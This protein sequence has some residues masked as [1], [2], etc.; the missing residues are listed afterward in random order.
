MPAR[1]LA[2]ALLLALC[3]GCATFSTST[4]PEW[5]R[6]FG[7]RVRATL[8]LQLADPCAPASDT[9]AGMDGRKARAA[10]Q[11]YQKAAGEPAA[12]AAGMSATNY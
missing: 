11:H 5:D 3:A 1:S 4:T 10:Y 8:A 2:L 6:Q 12:P 9:A 7:T